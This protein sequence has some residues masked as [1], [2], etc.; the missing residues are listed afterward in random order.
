[1]AALEFATEDGISGIYDRLIDA[2]VQIFHGEAETFGELRLIPMMQFTVRMPFEPGNLMAKWTV[3]PIGKRRFAKVTLTL[4]DR[5]LAET[6]KWELKKA[7][8]YRM[9]EVEYPADSHNATSQEN[10]MLV[11]IRGVLSDGLDYDGKNVLSMESTR[12]GT[13]DPPEQTEDAAPAAAAA[14]QAAPAAPDAKKTWIEIALKDSQGHPIPNERYKLKLADGSIRE[15][16]LD[17]DGRAR[18]DG[19]EPGSA[20]VS[21]PDQGT[22]W[23]PA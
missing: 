7:F 6:H 14:T 1:M 3:A 5:T 9:E 11:V 13:T 18:V 10:A 20:E 19:I 21:F 23:K 8:V 17:G 2:R 16:T 12:G 15:G 22:D 4:T